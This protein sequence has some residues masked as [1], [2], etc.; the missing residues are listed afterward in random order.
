[1]GEIT[2]TCL[3]ALRD[4]SATVRRAAVDTLAWRGQASSPAAVLEALKTRALNDPSAQVR[5]AAVHAIGAMQFWEQ[6]PAPSLWDLFV[7]WLRRPAPGVI[8][9][10]KRIALLLAGIYSI[11]GAAATIVS[12][13]A[14]GLRLLAP[15]IVSGSR[16]VR[17]VLARIPLVPALLLLAALLVAVIYF[18]R[19]RRVER[20]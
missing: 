16:S 8:G 11:F 18:M 5:E 10:L 20:H 4:D 19:G 14:Q 13:S 15:T 12:L 7:G 3:A 1:M 2:E 9:R 6:L 17:L